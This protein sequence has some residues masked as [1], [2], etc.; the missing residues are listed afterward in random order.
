[1]GGAPE[2]AALLSAACDGLFDA[3]VG[4]YERAFC[5]D[6]FGSVTEELA[7]HG[8]QVWLPEVGWSGRT[9]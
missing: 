2:A 9:R 6:Q 5:G 7:A 4:E 8:V 3:V 1:M